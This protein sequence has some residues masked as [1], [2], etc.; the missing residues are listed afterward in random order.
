MTT[1]E[2]SHSLRA[3]LLGLLM[4]VITLAALLQ[5]ST[6]YLT[7]LSQADL[8]FDRHMQKMALSLRSASALTSSTPNADVSLDRANEDFFV[9]MWTAGGEPVFQSAAHQTLRKPAQPGFSD[10]QSQDRMYRVFSVSTPTQIIQVAQD[11][12][13]RRD[14]ARALALRTIGPTVLMAPVLMLIVWWV[15]S[16]SLAPVAR[17]RSQMAQ[18]RADELSP[19]SEVGLPDE[20]RP[21]IQELNLLLERVRQAFDAQTVFVAD[22]AHEMRSPLAALK[23]QLQGLQRAGD[24]AARELGIK[25]LAAGID[26][27]AHLVDQL[28]VLARQEARMATGV[29]FT[30]IDLAQ[31]GILCVEDTLFAAQGR[32]IDL[33]VHRTE[34]V[35]VN[36]HAE[37]LR[38]LA[39]NLLDNAVKYTPE[40]GTVD[41][42]V[43]AT[44]GGI[45]LSVEDSGPG[46]AEADRGR[47]LDRFY[48]ASGASATGSGLGLAIVH[49]IANLHQASVRLDHSSRLGGLRVRV[50]FRPLGS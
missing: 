20:I 28:L 13:A 33:G 30:P 48:R 47:V 7:A 45:V 49:A 26:R 35:I 5:G 46:I 6:A 37:A 31:V 15:V 40:G 32:R 21:L 18:R 25:R 42:N 16:R 23:I 2:K 36:G 4:V 44:A 41:L 10:I 24:D 12:A 29:D 43:E 38:I 50:T 14:M 3:R 17:V 11:M 1:Q 34:T 8:I 19:L 22:A 9:Q 39:R 27:A